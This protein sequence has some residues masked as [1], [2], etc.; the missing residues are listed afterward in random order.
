MEWNLR[1][2]LNS[3]LEAIETVE[4]YGNATYKKDGFE[5]TA[6]GISPKMVIVGWEC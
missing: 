4:N 6:E 1:L 2:S 3:L 5:N